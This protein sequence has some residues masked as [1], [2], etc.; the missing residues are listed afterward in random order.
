MTQSA[1]AKWASILATNYQRLTNCDSPEASAAPQL[2]SQIG[3]AL[4]YPEYLR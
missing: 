4:K 2:F 1:I 3:F